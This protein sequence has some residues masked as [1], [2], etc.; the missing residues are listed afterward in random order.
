MKHAKKWINKLLYPPTWVLCTVP[1]VVFALLIYLFQTDRAEGT[2]A[3]IVFCLS[4]YSLVIWCIAIPKAVAT[5]EKWKPDSFRSHDAE[6]CGGHH[7]DP[8]IAN[9]DDCPLL[10]QR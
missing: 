10:Y 1:P 9:G 7:V 8:R 3:N 2:S 6:P 5:Y 4:A